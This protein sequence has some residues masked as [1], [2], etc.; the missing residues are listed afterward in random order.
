MH[1]LMGSLRPAD[2][3]TLE[4]A[5]TRNRMP[6]RTLPAEGA[7]QLGADLLA[8]FFQEGE[9]SAL[10]PADVRRHGAYAIQI[11]SAVASA[12][13]LRA[14][15]AGY[16]LVFPSPLPADRVTRFLRYMSDVA[17]PPKSRTLTLSENG[18][19][20]TAT[21]HAELDPAESAALRLLGSRRDGIVS[22]AELLAASGSDPLQTVTALRRH[23]S[24]LGSG[25]QILKVP[26]LGYR[27]VG[28]VQDAAG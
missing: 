27:L 23:L 14:I 21:G 9:E 26:H 28:S 19:L 13:M 18:T 10:A 4:R 11:Q 16:H 24:E 3:D 25:A 6:L 12:P 1:V 2:A 8:V 17:A 20:S 22:R 5:C 15:R 7:G